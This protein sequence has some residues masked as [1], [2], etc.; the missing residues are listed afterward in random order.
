MI[1]KSSLGIFGASKNRLRRS[2]R[3][4]AL[5]VLGAAVVSGPACRPHSSPN[6]ALLRLIDLLIDAGVVESPLKN[7]PREDGGGV[8][9]VDSMAMAEAGSGEHAFGLKRKLNLT[10]VDRDILFAPPRTEFKIRLSP[11]AAG[12]LDFGIGIVRD[13]HS[14]APIAGNGPGGVKFILIAENHGRKKVLFE[15]L[16]RPPMIRPNRTVA[17]A[18]FR[19]P[20]PALPGETTLTLITVGESGLFSFW[21][22]PVFYLPQKAP[23]NVI[24]ISLDTL[25]ADHVGTYGYSRPVTPHIDALAA[26]GA[27]FENVFSTSPWTIPAHASMF[28]GLNC[29]RHRL[30]DERGR[31]DPRT[32]TLAEKMREKGFAT[33]AITNGGFVSAMFGF[34]KGFDEYHM[35]NWG[36][37]D[38]AEA[39]KTGKEA[40]EWIASNTDRSFFLFLHTYQIHL[41]Y[42]S[43]EPYRSMFLGPHPRWTSYDLGRNGGGLEGV[44]KSFSEADRDN[45][46]ALYDAGIRYADET[47]IKPLVDELHRLGMYDRTMIIVTA[48]HGE[49]FFDHRCWNHAHSVYNE[50]LHVPLIIKMPESKYR[51]RRFPSI[52]RLIDIMPTVLD[53]F[54]IPTKD[55]SLN[56]ASLVPV[57]KGREKEDRVFLAELSD[58]INGNK[59]PQRLALNSGRIKV[60]LNHPFT[61]EEFAFFSDKPPDFPPIEVYDLSRD[62][63]EKQNLV[64]QPPDPA[65]TRILIQKA[66]ESDRL[67][68]KRGT[69][70]MKVDKNLEDQLR[71]LGYIK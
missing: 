11:G 1:R 18:R 68:P 51:G 29:V 21:E 38:P 23:M 24:L 57:L 63:L 6:P 42:K 34:A 64:R 48:D 62:P 10:I 49:E 53:V 15:R 66:Q 14:N 5:F 44:Y 30:Y 55:L 59:I 54:G 69:G 17:Q 71:A 27:V 56:G 12:I 19:I 31:M 50:L 13:V 60:I 45:I 46:V 35:E 67:I 41:P 16:L 40:V 39:G 4:T 70:K 47:L 33:Y 25:R 36:F 28:S 7:R 26:D 37:E 3:W 8:Y 9:P 43:P 58:D 52:V 61:P 22:N 2:A 32:V 65:R 20:L